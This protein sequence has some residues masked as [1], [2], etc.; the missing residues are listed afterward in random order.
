MQERTSVETQL[1]EDTLREEFSRMLAEK[2]VE[3]KDKSAKVEHAEQCL[4]TLELE[5]K[6]VESKIEL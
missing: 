2:K 6:V 3:I 1:R 4:M 5:L